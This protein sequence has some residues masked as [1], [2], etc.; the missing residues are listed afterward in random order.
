MPKE[1]PQS[2]LDLYKSYQMPEEDM[3]ELESLIESGE[4]VIP[5][6][7]V[8]A[9]EE[10]VMPTFPEQ[11]QF[12]STTAA[13]QE[14]EAEPDIMDLQPIGFEAKQPEPWPEYINNIEV[15]TRRS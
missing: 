1:V 13:Y 2:V 12:E 5:N 15:L 3:A 8:K 6:Q 11:P 7:S 10:V 14:P 9:N 4:L